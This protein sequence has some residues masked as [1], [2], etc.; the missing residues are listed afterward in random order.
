MSDVNE[1]ALFELQDDGRLMPVNDA[2]KQRFELAQTVNRYQRSITKDMIIFMTVT[3]V[4][5]GGVGL[6]IAI[7]TGGH[8]N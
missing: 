8:W 2:A 1:K 5:F 6:L 3:I 4:I 7:F